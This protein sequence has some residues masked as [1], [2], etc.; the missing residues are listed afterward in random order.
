MLE[1][2]INTKIVKRYKPLHHGHLVN[3]T[4]ITYYLNGLKEAIKNSTSAHYFF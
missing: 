3:F 2:Q 4:Y 1:T